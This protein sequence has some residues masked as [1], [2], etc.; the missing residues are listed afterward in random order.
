MQIKEPP[1]EELT[2]QTIRFLAADAVQAANSGHPGTP[3]GA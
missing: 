1:I 2:I 3:M